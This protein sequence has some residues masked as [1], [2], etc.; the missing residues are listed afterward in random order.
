MVGLSTGDEVGSLSLG[1]GKFQKVLSG[2]L[3]GGF[4]RLGAYFP[5]QRGCGVS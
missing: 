3:E 4:D 2:H 1:F 5:D